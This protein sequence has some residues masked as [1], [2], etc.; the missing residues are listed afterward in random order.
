MSV[1]EQKVVY[2]V[3]F[4]S[5]PTCLMVGLL[6]TMPIPHLLR[7]PVLP[8]TE[9]PTLL[10]RGSFIQESLRK[11]KPTKKAKKKKSS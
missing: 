3:W 11:K 6:K 5:V 2:A 1:A 4:C 8:G 9:Q 10:K 7:Q